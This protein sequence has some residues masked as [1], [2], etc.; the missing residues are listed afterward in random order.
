VLPDYT[1][2]KATGYGA[3]ADFF[4][5]PHFGAELDYHHAAISQHAPATE[6]SFDYGII[7]RRIYGKSRPFLRASAGRGSLNFP[8][9][10]TGP[11]ASAAYLS[12]NQFTIAGGLDFEATRF[13]NIRAELEYQTWLAAPGLINGLTPTLFTVGAAYHFNPRYP[14]Y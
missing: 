4:V 13:I 7:Y 11:S 6:V 1:P 3:Y 14:V 5:T 10:T 2:Q 8:T 9:G 12:Y